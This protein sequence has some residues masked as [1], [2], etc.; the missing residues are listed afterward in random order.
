MRIGNYNVP[1]TVLNPYVKHI[2]FRYLKTC[3]A[4][5]DD[6]GT[7]EL[8]IQREKLHNVILEKI[9]LTRK[10]PGYHDFETALEQYCES[11]LPEKQVLK[12]RMDLNGA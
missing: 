12:N 6:N 11:M 9:G 7:Y 1:K 10:D 3:Q 8:E 5:P 4:T 2:I